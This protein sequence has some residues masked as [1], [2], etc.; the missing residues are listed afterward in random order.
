MSIQDLYK[1]V[2]N[3]EISQ[4]RFLYFVRKDPRL[5]SIITN[6]ISFEDAIKNLKAKSIIWEES[7]NNI[8]EFD[9]IGSIKKLQESALYTDP[10]IMK[11][12]NNADHVNYYEFENGWRM[13]YQKII[14]S[15]SNKNKID[16]E[17]AIEKA[18][19]K[20]IKNIEKDPIYY[21]R[22][23]SGEK[24]SK[25]RTDLP[26]EVDKKR[27]NVV[28]KPNQMKSPKGFKKDKSNVSVKKEK[29]KKPQGIKTMKGGSGG[30][31]TEKQLKESSTNE[32][33]PDHIV[34]QDYRD[35][36]S[37][38]PDGEYDLHKGEKVQLIYNSGI[39][40]LTV[41]T[42]SGEKK[43][44]AGFSGNILQRLPKE[45]KPSKDELKEAIK[46][47]KEASK[48]LK[49]KQKLS[50]KAKKEVKKAIGDFYDAGGCSSIKEK[51][52]KLKGG[53]GDKLSLKDVD[54]QE[55]KK[56][57]KH[58]MEH[59]NDPKIAMEIALDH[60]AEDPHY[61]S[62]NKCSCLK[63]APKYNAKKNDYHFYLCEI[64]NGK[65]VINE[66]FTYKEDAI[67]RKKEQ[68]EEGHTGG[69][70]FKVFSEK[71]LKSKGVDP[72]NDSNWHNPSYIKEKTKDLNETMSPTNLKRGKSY[73]Y[74][75]GEK[76]IDVEY[77]GMLTKAKKPY[78]FKIL[79]KKGKDANLD[80]TAVEISRFIQTYN[81]AFLARENMSVNKKGNLKQSV[82]DFNADRCKQQVGHGKKYSFKIGPNNKFSV[83]KTSK[84]EITLY[85]DTDEEIDYIYKNM[86]DAIDDIIIMINTYDEADDKLG[87][88]GESIFDSPGKSVQ[89]KEV[90]FT[91]QGKNDP[92]E[93]IRITK[94][95]KSGK[96]NPKKGEF[97]ITFKSGDKLIITK[98][99]YG[100]N[101]VYF[102]DSDHNKVIDL[103][104]S[105]SD[106][107]DKVFPKEKAAA[108]S[109]NNEG[110][111]IEELRKK[112]G[113]DN[114]NPE[115]FQ[116]TPK[117]YEEIIRIKEFH[118]LINA[119]KIKVSH[120]K[121]TQH[122]LVLLNGDPETHQKVSS[123]IDKVHDKIGEDVVKRYP[124]AVKDSPNKDL[125]EEITKKPKVVPFD[126]DHPNRLKDLKARPDQLLK[127]NQGF[128][129]YGTVW[130]I[131]DPDVKSAY[132]SSGHDYGS[133]KKHRSSSEPLKVI[134]KFYRQEGTD[135]VV[136][137]RGFDVKKLKD[138]ILDYDFNKSMQPPT[139][140]KEVL[141]KI[142]RKKIQEVQIVGPHEKAKMLNDLMKRYDWYYEDSDDPQLKQRAQETHDLAMKL[143]NELGDKGIEIFNSYAPD[144]CQ[145]SSDDI[146]SVDK[147]STTANASIVNPK[148]TAEPTYEAMHVDKS[149][150]LR[151]YIE[152]NFDRDKM[153]STLKKNVDY[154]FSIGDKEYK[155]IINPYAEG[156]LF[157]NN[158]GKR[159][160]KEKNLDDLADSIAY[161][162]KNSY[163]DLAEEI[164]DIEVP[165]K[166]K[167]DKSTKFVTKDTH[168][169]P[170]P[171]LTALYKDWGNDGLY[172]DI[173][174]IVASNGGAEKPLS[175]KA[176]QLIVKKLR[177]Y[178]EYEYYE[179]YLKV[180][181]NENEDQTNHQAYIEKM[182][183]MT[184]Q[185]I[186]DIVLSNGFAKDSIKNKVA[187][188]ILAQYV[189]D[190]LKDP[191]VNQALHK[192][193]DLNKK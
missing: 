60:L 180:S 112:I 166:N 87:E 105:L 43:S 151:H 33:K 92:D 123:I 71:F 19:A 23:I 171:L 104:K 72:N 118:D 18:K 157:I 45:D 126:Y 135:I 131:V 3:E 148:Q 36:W 187:L 101:A 160:A 39:G 29:A 41:K 178:Q 184:P 109:V 48:F 139:D 50:P 63:E 114:P 14:K 177:G 38:L 30:K 106:L 56:G 110:K 115:I 133:G 11:K 37:E 94:I 17:Q 176:Y 130:L 140:I 42:A 77:M 93:K 96:K 61:Y 9:F 2:L 75:G 59:T 21:T 99:D 91:I 119:K 170:K 189:K 154:D 127:F 138:E 111:I 193:V 121:G 4:E 12:K 146:T 54:K 113:K 174:H 80:L 13:E 145:I 143:V 161:A 53:L 167:S 57:I 64:I 153:K 20:A 35:R 129:K 116:L 117:G 132:S 66:G 86:D 65:I 149:G 83:Y 34:T 78:M 159:M 141:R 186:A 164:E 31:T 125:N 102:G 81:D 156:F 44:I 62:D 103:D 47:F 137:L 49:K 88:L 89:G 90:A 188:K 82:S 108:E 182:K 192:L 68:E 175:D 27:S 58:E 155:V 172:S 51:S 22:L 163:F 124:W 122:F 179:D 79:G 173:S 15:N 40:S 165:G 190:G 158:E 162:I 144:D 98:S 134:A 16:M 7:S 185:E 74:S 181:I 67:A 73:I 120:G 5:S 168:I 8:E 32:F 183:E 97:E 1:Q 28:D 76:D 70:T 52:D 136:D 147:A 55:L 169:D 152:T 10:E 26:I 6:S 142:I 85:N 107:S 46:V 150:K 128:G 84:G 95:V 24:Q 100:V 69:L 25:K 191:K